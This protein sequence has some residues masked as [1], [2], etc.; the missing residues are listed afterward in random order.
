LIETVVSVAPCV[1]GIFKHPNLCGEHK[2]G[3]A[4][5]MRLGGRRYEA[6]GQ[7]LDGNNNSFSPERR[8][9]V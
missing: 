9:T 2:R 1:G 3:K 4:A 7:N 6:A 8:C 5:R